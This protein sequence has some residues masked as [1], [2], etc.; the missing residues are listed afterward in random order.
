[1][2]FQ[3]VI[4]QV[5]LLHEKEEW[6]QEITDEHGAI[7]ELPDMFGAIV[8]ESV[9]LIKEALISVDQREEDILAYKNAYHDLELL[10]QVRN[11]LINCQYLCDNNGLIKTFFTFSNNN[12]HVKPSLN[13]AIIA[14]IKYSSE[15]SYKL[16]ITFTL[17]P[18]YA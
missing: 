10:I 6:H 1:M 11:H 15:I 12:L 9:Q 2:I 8:S 17:T 3:T 16:I 4:D 5:H 7:T 18:I 14:L 13:K